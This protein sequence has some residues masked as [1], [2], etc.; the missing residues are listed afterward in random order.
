[1]S[2]ESERL[3]NKPAKW[4]IGTKTVQVESLPAGAIVQILE[5]IKK[6]TKLASP[7]KAIELMGSGKDINVFIKEFRDLVKEDLLTEV[8]N[9][10]ELYRLILIPADIWRKTRGDFSEFKDEDY[11]VTQDDIEWNATE[12]LLLDIWTEFWKRNARFDRQKKM[13]DVGL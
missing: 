13:A 6:R 2:R 12:D 10:W 9:D 5:E 7:E 11:P 1:M 8:E 4:T 3:T